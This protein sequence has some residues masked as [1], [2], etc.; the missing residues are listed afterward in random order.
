MRHLGYLLLF[1]FVV[2]LLWLPG[3]SSGREQGALR[4]A[5][6]PK[7]TTHEYWKAIHAGAEKA[8][9]DLGKEGIKVKIIWKG[10]EKEDDREAQITVVENFISARVSGI[11]IAPLDE[12]ALVRPVEEAVDSGI[13]VVVIDSGL[14]SDK[15][16]SFVATDNYKGGMLGARRLAEILGGKGKVFMLRYQ[17]G[18][19]STKNREKGFLHKIKEYPGIEVVSA[20]Q[21]GGPT[22]E[23]AYRK[24]ESLLRRFPDVDG[25]FCPNESTTFGTLRA[26]QDAGRAGK[27]KFVGFDS[28]AKLIQALRKKEIQGL[29]LQ[30]PFYMGEMGVKTLV[31]HIKGLE[32][33]KRID[34][35]VTVA[36]PGNMDEP[37]IRF[38]LNPPLEKY[39]G[40]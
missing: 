17:E 40:K 33:E 39:L 14:A 11:V 15:Q 26:L 36:T 6:I 20:E 29:V 3:C 12:K 18:S 22:T 25:I 30:N 5:V 38:L 10:P 34:T 1:P 31:R 35:G 27:V 24:A 2:A 21:Y 32:V 9:E 7:G 28:S 23:T 4:I 13:P 19:E 16:V 8:R 37:D